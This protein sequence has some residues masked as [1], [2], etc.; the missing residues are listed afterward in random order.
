MLG[1]DLGFLGR[2]S[3]SL[4][5]PFTLLLCNHLQFESYYKS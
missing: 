1:Y 2:V 4:E 3:P 5:Y